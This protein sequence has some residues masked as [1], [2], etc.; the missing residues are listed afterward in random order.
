MSVQISKI[1]CT[2]C[3]QGVFEGKPNNEKCSHCGTPLTDE[4]MEA[5]M[6]RTSEELKRGIKPNPEFVIN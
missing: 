3:N 6:K 1:R 4:L 2:K 5:D